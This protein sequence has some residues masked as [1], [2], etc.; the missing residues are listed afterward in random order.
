MLRPTKLREMHPIPGTSSPIYQ[1][2][3]SDPRCRL[4]PARG[5][6]LSD[7]APGMYQLLVT[8]FELDYPIEHPAIYLDFGEGFKEA[9]EVKIPLRAITNE[10]Y[11]AEFDLGHTLL[12]LRLDATTRKGA[13]AIGPIWIQPRPGSDHR[14]IVDNPAYRFLR[15]ALTRILPSG[16]ANSSAKLSVL[17]RL[18]T[19]CLTSEELACGIISDSDRATLHRE[20]RRLLS[21]LRSRGDYRALYQ[22]QAQEAAGWRGKF[23]VAATTVPV[24]AGRCIV[25]PIAF[26]LPQFHPIPENDQLWGKG[27]TEWTN[28]AKAVPQFEGH[29]Q[30][31]YPGELGY[32]DLRLT[33]VM[34]EQIRLAKTYGLHGFCFHHYW[35]HGRRLLERPVDQF[36]ADASLDFKFCICWAN[37]NWTR[38]WD[39]AEHEVL[40]G[41]EHSAADDLEFFGDLAR[42]MRDPRYIRVDGKPVLVVYRP[43]LLPSAKQTA[44][45]WRGEASKR[46]FGGLFLVASNAFGFTDPASIGFDALVEFPPHGRTAAPINDTLRLYNPEYKGQ[47]YSYAEIARTALSPYPDDALV[48]PGAMPSWDNEARRPGRG[49]VM[50]GSTP[51]LFRDW[52]DRCFLRAR[53][54]AAAHCPFVFI[55]AWNEWA[56]A[57]YLEPDLRFG[58]AYLSAVSDCIETHS[59]TLPAARSSA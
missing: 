56:E 5:G 16:L 12:G 24:D 34:R 52:L 21:A 15:S 31:R 1:A 6:A 55:N 43:N 45:R 19:G 27:F 47:V 51:E 17:S 18:F 35:F 25:K 22:N 37:E 32:Y 54:N 57:A 33:E 3:S 7:L 38:T 20:A 53:R 46:G 44:A 58:Y 14:Q 10:I 28:V 40:I 13:F 29:Y 36:L 30:P 59:E 41:Q 4:E 23:H 48:I 42:Y 8:I 2:E 49:N 11:A 9:D 39:G 26:Y 50:H